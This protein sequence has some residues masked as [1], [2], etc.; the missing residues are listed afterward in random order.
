MVNPLTWTSYIDTIARL[1]VVAPSDVNFLSLAPQMVSYAELRILRDVDLLNTVATVPGYSLIANRRT[2]TVPLGVFVTL[3]EIN[4]I[5]PVGTADPDAGVRHTMYPTT[6]EY[7][8]AVHNS[9]AGAGLPTCFAMIS[10]S[11]IAFGPWPDANYAL[12]IVGTVRPPSLSSTNTSTF[13]STYL[14]DLFV[15]A[16]MVWISGYQR[17]FGRQSDDPQMAVSFESQ[18]QTLLKGTVIEEARK[19]FQS[20]AWSSLSPAPVASPSRNAA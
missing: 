3:Q 5:T 8:N 11:L 1:A 6:K 19:K 20:A 2:V 18:Y 4:A 12:E 9:A 16:S 15:M 14:P 7:I 17:N 13:I 10:D